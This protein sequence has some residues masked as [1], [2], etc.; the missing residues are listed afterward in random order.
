[1]TQMNLKRA[2]KDFYALAKSDF[3]LDDFDPICKALGAYQK[4]HPADHPGRIAPNRVIAL[5][6]VRLMEQWETAEWAKQWETAEWAR[7]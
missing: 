6:V 5:A 2:Y 3:P 4:K 7:E 1:M